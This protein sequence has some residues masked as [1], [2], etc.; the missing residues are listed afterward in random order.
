M[1]PKNE[2]SKFK[3]AHHISTSQ[4]AAWC[5]SWAFREKR[6]NWG[7]INPENTG[8]KVVQNYV[9]RGISR[10]VCFHYII[11]NVISSLNSPLINHCTTVNLFHLFRASPCVKFQLTLECLPVKVMAK[12][13]D[14]K[15]F[16]QG[17]P[18]SWGVM[19]MH[20]SSFL[21]RMKQL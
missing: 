16:V 19:H 21:A 11:Q 17:W 7:F 8:Y 1:E 4:M 3:E 13:F 5:W 20:S 2:G 9:V 6:K 18:A 12:P 14:S 10:K 15:S